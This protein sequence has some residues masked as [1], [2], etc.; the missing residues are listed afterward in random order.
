MNPPRDPIARAASTPNLID[1][2]QPGQE[3]LREFL[4]P[5]LLDARVY[6]ID[7][8]DCPV[9]LDQNE[10]PFDW[11]QALKDKVLKRLSTTAWNRYP[12]AYNDEL[13]ASVARHCGVN[14]GSVLL[15][16]GSNYLI[17][18]L[19]STF[20]RRM[21]GKVVIARPS[22]AL[23]ESHCHYEGIP[24][25]L[26]NLDK[27]MQYDVRQLPPLVPGSIVVFA[28]P[29]NP[30]GN[31]LPVRELRAL[32]TTHPDVLFF[33]DEA[34]VEFSAE[35]YT[36]LLRDFHNLVLLRTFS[37]TMGAAGVRLGYLIGPRTL[38]AELRKLRLP[39]MI[40][41]FA[42]IAADVA[43]TDPETTEHFRKLVALA[44]AERGKMQRR[45]AAV[46]AKSKHGFAVVESSANF[47]LLRWQDVSAAKRA[48][49]AMVDA[50]VLVRDVSGGR[51]LDGCLRVTVGQES[52]NQKFLDAAERVW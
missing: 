33:A 39:F 37:K 45:L 36:E 18:L 5:S 3:W 27:N 35:P 25:E 41:Q 2:P 12:S 52:E 22:F 28:S 15:G 48:Y 20:T 47:I 21:S 38:I 42:A 17:A 6:R 44:Q 46:G 10:S 11:P 26:W 19:L 40:N 43:L 1:P 14:P 24:Y 23:Y 4:T 31:V 34:Y 16:P 32:L 7:T 51:G 8:P 50:G 9:K 13:T 49:Q 30:V 29:N